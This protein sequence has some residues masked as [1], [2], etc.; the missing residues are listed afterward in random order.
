MMRHHDYS[1]VWGV[2]LI[3]LVGCAATRPASLAPIRVG[4]SGDY[5]PFSVDREGHLSG[6][7]IDVMNQ[8]THDLGFQP[9]FVL[10]GWPTLATNV[11][12]GSFDL[13]ASGITMR[14]ERALIGRYSRPYAIVGAVVIL[15]STEKAAFS[16]VSLLNDPAVRIVVNAGGHLEHVTRARFPLATIIAVPDNAELPRKVLDGSAD[17]AVS[18]SAEAAHWLT[19]E[20]RAIGPFTR[21]YKA[22]L[23]PP[24]NEE[25]PVRIDA[26]MVAHERDGWL[27][28]ERGRW[29]GDSARSNADEMTRESVVA[30]INL[31]L[32]LMPEVGAAKIAAN[33]RIDDAAQEQ[34]VIARVREAAPDP[35]HVEAVYRVLIELSKIVQR[36]AVN[37]RPVASLTELR[38]AIVRIDKQLVREL[39]RTPPTSAMEW[40]NLLDRTLTVPGIDASATAFLAS[41]L[42]G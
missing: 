12:T 7:D 34:L 25:L 39:G 16:D 32:A 31:R 9:T 6:L 37:A 38:A 30:L 33:L 2:L 15:R 4:T 40:T 19:P 42:A 3:A 13:A 20:L 26:W 17:A 23:Y 28:Q 24:G 10:F 18:D 41:A 27:P 11:A 29:L 36:Q 5:V 22:F 21:D 35:N 14:P 1:R 8:L